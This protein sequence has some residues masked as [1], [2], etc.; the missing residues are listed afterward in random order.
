[1]RT[2]NSQFSRE[3]EHQ[4][5]EFLDPKPFTHPAAYYLSQG[6][7]LSMQA[8]F[9]RHCLKICKLFILFLSMS[10]ICPCTDTHSFFP[11]AYLLNGH[12]FHSGMEPSS[13]WPLLHICLSWCGDTISLKLIFSPLIIGN[14]GFS[15]PNSADVCLEWPSGSLE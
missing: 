6:A 5:E 1:M 10:L 13:L 8:V 7:A 11:W 4:L 9:Q 15:M 12:A 2:T 3:M 14:D